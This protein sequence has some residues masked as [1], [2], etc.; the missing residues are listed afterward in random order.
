LS[1]GAV[2]ETVMTVLVNNIEIPDA[3][4][5]AEMQHHPAESLEAAHHQ[6]ALSLV[7][8][9]LLRQAVER[10]GIVGETE[11][12]RIQSLLER[13]ARTPAPDDESCQRYFRNNR[14]RFRTADLYGAHHILFAAAPDDDQARSVAREKAARA[15]ARLE[16]ETESFEDVAREFS[17]C[18]SGSAGGD[19]G[20]VARGTTVPEFE[21]FLCNLED[22]QLCPVP[23]ETRYGF[24]V[25]R[26]DGHVP[27][28]DQPYEAVKEI[29]AGYL[30]D[31]SYHRAVQQYL[32]ILAG[33]AEIVGIELDG[34]ESLLV[35]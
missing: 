27:G 1:A 10:H 16:N 23:V 9:E 15:I 3:A 28:R 19:L 12:S 32:R 33:A 14:L 25:L 35:Q 20:W 31:C 21:T 18:P 4:I 17:D 24:H 11:E 5:H 22:G 7:I 29:V 26:R 6:A 13:E 30:A 2:R 8:R 34:A